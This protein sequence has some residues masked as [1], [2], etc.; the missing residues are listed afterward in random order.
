MIRG[1]FRWISKRENVG[2]L[3]DGLNGAFRLRKAH[4][5]YFAK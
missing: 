5:E 2:F 4:A 1:L 3:V